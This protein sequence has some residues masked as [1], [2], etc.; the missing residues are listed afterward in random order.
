MIISY[1]WF[2]FRKTTVNNYRNVEYR[3]KIKL[4][5]LWFGNFYTSSLLV[6]N[7]NNNSFSVSIAQNTHTHK[8]KKNRISPMK[9]SS[10]NSFL[11]VSIAQKEKIW[12]KID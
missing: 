2:N 6:K 7:T 11:C 1:T 5:N 12:I 8:K 3:I 9:S 4:K 10:D